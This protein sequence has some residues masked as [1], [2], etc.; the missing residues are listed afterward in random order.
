MSLFATV[1]PGKQSF[2]PQFG[3]FLLGLVLGLLVAHSLVAQEA[4]KLCLGSEQNLFSC[5][6][7]RRLV[8]VCAGKATSKAYV[9]LRFGMPG[10]LEASWPPADSNMSGVTK[11]VVIS[12]GAF[13]V[14]V[15]F[16][17]EK[18]AFVVY[19]VPGGSSGLVTVQ[20]SRV[21]TK[22]ICRKLMTSKIEDVPVPEGS[23]FAVSGR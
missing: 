12:Q 2:R 16:A 10:K 21:Q 22:E 11:G 4:D 8:S 6:T 17:V 5:D 19:E 15:R 18:G 14:Y 20:S 3:R 9:Q 13:G 1:G 7:G 23:V